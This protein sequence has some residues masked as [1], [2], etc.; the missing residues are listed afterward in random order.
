MY[1][2]LN[3]F[4]LEEDNLVVTA[5]GSEFKLYTFPPDEFPPVA[6]KD[7]GQAISVVS[8]ELANVSSLTV[9]AAAK[10]TTRYAI[11]GLLMEIEG[12]KL[13]M[14]GTDGRRLAKAGITLSEKASE[15]I[16]CI[17]PTR[18]VQML[19]RLT[20]QEDAPI[21]IQITESQI[22]F[23]VAGIL[24]VSSIIEGKFP[25]YDAVIPKESTCKV[26]INR[27]ELLGALRRAALLASR[28]SH[29]V[30]VQLDH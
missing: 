22:V 14:V 2:E 4:S 20:V 1:I 12:S 6:P 8:S 28:E 9:Y 7:Q 10:E 3:T 13:I 5:A 24:L 18:A 16:S 30:K 17:V 23:K 15:A 29:G 19:S 25:S 21:G 26:K 11:N 27:L